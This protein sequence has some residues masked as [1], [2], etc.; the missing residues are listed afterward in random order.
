MRSYLKLRRA[1]IRSVVA[2][3][4]VIVLAAENIFQIIS[5]NAI[6]LTVLGRIQIRVRSGYIGAN[7]AGVDNFERHVCYCLLKDG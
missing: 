7:A 2:V 4:V 6:E 3:A 1:K 5:R